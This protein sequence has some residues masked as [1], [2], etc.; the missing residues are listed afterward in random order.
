MESIELSGMISYEE[1]KIAFTYKN[2]KL[3]LMT[4]GYFVEETEE[5]LTFRACSFSGQVIH[6]YG[7]TRKR[8]LVNIVY[9]VDYVVVSNYPDNH[10]NFDTMRISGGLLDLLHE[11]FENIFS[12]IDFDF[13]KMNNQGTYEVKTKKWDESN[14]VFYSSINKMEVEVIIGVP[15]KMPINKKNVNSTHSY[16]LVKFGHNIDAKDFK[17]YYLK[18]VSFL[19]VIAQKTGMSSKTVELGNRND[20]GYSKKVYFSQDKKHE[21]TN[22]RVSFRDYMNEGSTSELEKIFENCGKES[23]SYKYLLETQQAS[24][25]ITPSSMF[26]CLLSFEHLI[27]TK[28]L[29]ISNNK[30]STIE[31]AKQIIKEE[32]KE[33]DNCLLEKADLAL[34]HVYEPT[35]NDKINSIIENNKLLRDYLYTKYHLNNEGLKI[36]IRNLVSFRNKFAHGSDAIPAFEV[37]LDAHDILLDIN[38]YLLL[39]KYDVTEKIIIQMLNKK[40]SRNNWGTYFI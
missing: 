33:N 25:V 30:D 28:K 29:K 10:E 4:R 21:I 14:I 34:S 19:E 6:F 20:R 24:E 8:H 17:D 18:I 26:S 39:K 27:T 12:H 37:A 23:V 32:R 1:E 2:S 15:R 31:K 38:S 3:T 22:V 36:C 7:C 16:I 35:L 40:R 9:K 13:T 5:T 11:P